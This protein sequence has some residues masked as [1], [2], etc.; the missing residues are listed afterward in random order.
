MLTRLTMFPLSK[1]RPP[2]SLAWPPWA[3]QLGPCSAP[4]VLVR[5]PA[6]LRG[7]VAAA[8][9]WNMP[10]PDDLPDAPAMV[11]RFAYVP[12]PYDADVHEWPTLEDPPPWDDEDE[13]TIASDA[14]A[15]SCDVLRHRRRRRGRRRWS[16]AAGRRPARGA[17]S[18]RHEGLQIAVGLRQITAFSVSQAFP[19]SRVTSRWRELPCAIPEALPGRSWGCSPRSSASLCSRAESQRPPSLSLSRSSSTLGPSTDRAASAAAPGRALPLA[20]SPVS[21]GR[22]PPRPNSH[23]TVRPGGCHQHWRSSWPSS[24]VRTAVVAYVERMCVW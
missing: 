9:A 19:V 16:G 22:S 14:V 11:Q 3:G 17:P 20:R 12:P 24:W 8:T 2:G 7:T 21:V 13:D 15:K 4:G 5:L 18:R 23:R 1:V 10:A 6:R